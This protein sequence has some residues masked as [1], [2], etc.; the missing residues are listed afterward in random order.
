MLLQWIIAFVLIHIVV[1]PCLPLLNVP[2]NGNRTTIKEYGIVKYI[3]FTCNH[4]YILKG[5][6]LA[7]CDN[8]TWSSS[9]PT[10]NKP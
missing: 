1:N 4:N 3:S 9:T 5:K 2:E 8:G 10:C 7:T 6:S